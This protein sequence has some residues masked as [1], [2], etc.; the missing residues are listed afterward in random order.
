MLMRGFSAKNIGETYLIKGLKYFFLVDVI[1]LFSTDNQTINYFHLVHAG[2]L[3]LLYFIGKLQR[4]QRKLVVFQVMSNGN[5]FDQNNFHLKAEIGIILFALG[6]FSLFIFNPILA[7][8]PIS[9]WFHDS[10]LDI[11]KTKFFG[12]IFKVVG[13]IVTINILHQVIQSFLKLLSGELFQ[14]RPESIQNTKDTD[15]FDDFEEIK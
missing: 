12:F 14:P 15:D 13:F 11:E 4:Q 2:L 6:I 3:I 10:I 5:Q 1:F 8:N 9:V 7:N